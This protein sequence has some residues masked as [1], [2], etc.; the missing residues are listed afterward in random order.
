MI[1]SSKGEGGERT[2]R[3]FGTR[4][5]KLCA[6]GLTLMVVVSMFAASGIYDFT[7]PS[8]D[9]NPAPLSSYKGRVV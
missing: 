7:L 1:Y 2:M 4:L 3:I 5:C 9:G 8:I 6:G